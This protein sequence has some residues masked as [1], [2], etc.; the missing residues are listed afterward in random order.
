MTQTRFL[1]I[2]DYLLTTKECK[3]I[4]QLLDKEDLEIVDR[5]E[6]ASYS[7]NIWIDD[8]FADE[9]Y[10]RVYSYLPTGTVRCNEHIRFSKYAPGQEFNLHTDGLNRDAY[11]NQ[12]KYT[13]NIFLNHGFVG[14]ETEFFQE[15]G[16]ISATPQAGRA[17][18][19]DREILHRGNRVLSGTKYLLRTDV[20][21]PETQ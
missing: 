4:I 6:L 10:S 12:S 15:G 13:V 17:V 18:L 5:G 20:M 16:S 9:I 1:K 14:G 19:F 11:G 21:I 8:E 2:V 3:R 7:R